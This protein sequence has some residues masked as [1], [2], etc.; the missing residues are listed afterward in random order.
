MAKMSKEQEDFINDCLYSASDRSGD[1]VL[2][3]TRLNIYEW[4]ATSL[5]QTKYTTRIELK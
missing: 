2:F 4:I 1:G 5:W 3:K